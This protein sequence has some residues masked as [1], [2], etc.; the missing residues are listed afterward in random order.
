MKRNERHCFIILHLAFVSTFKAETAET[1]GL[2]SEC[3]PESSQRILHIR[4]WDCLLV[5]WP[6]V[7]WYNHKEVN[8]LSG[9]AA[10][11]GRS[12]GL[13]VLVAG[14]L[15]FWIFIVTDCWG[16]EICRGPVDGIPLVML[17]HCFAPRWLMNVKLGL[18][19]QFCTWGCLIVDRSQTLSSKFLLVFFVFCQW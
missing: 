12:I 3:I 18:C 7:S 15:A 8:S 17:R 2:V 13:F 5:D 14:K 19:T 4:K 10:A 11:G 1:F 9:G 16:F 6:C